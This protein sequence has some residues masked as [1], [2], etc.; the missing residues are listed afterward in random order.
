MSFILSLI[1]F[2]KIYQVHQVD[3]RTLADTS[4]IGTS[5]ICEQPT[6]RSACVAAYSRQNHRAYHTLRLV[7]YMYM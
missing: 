7:V 5:R 2:T 6:L 4:E 1:P 3:R